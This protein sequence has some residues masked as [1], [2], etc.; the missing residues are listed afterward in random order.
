MN[1]MATLIH[2]GVHIFRVCMMQYLGFTLSWSSPSN[3]VPFSDAL[4]TVR[5][6]EI[7]LN[8]LFL[9][10]YLWN[11]KDFSPSAQLP[12][13]ISD[14]L[15]DKNNKPRPLVPMGQGHAHS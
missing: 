13:E 9:M 2:I 11:S 8:A 7:H 1:N 3:L 6:Y 12:P 10:L 5:V 15:G 4:K 14:T